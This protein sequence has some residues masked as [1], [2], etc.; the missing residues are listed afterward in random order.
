MIRYV[1]FIIQ[2]S[3]LTCVCFAQAAAAGRIPT[4]F[5]SIVPQKYFVQ[6][7]SKGRV[8][9][10]V[11]VQPGANPATYEPKPSQMAKL[12]SAAAYF[13]IGVPF[14]T[15]WLGKMS[16]INPRME[17]VR[18][19]RQIEKIAMAVHLHEEELEHG[20]HSEVDQRIL[21][22][23]IWL[24]PQLVKKQIET[25]LSGLTAIAPEYEEEFTPNSMIFLKKIDNLSLE[26]HS[27]L[28]GVKGKHFMVFHPS[29]GYFAREFGLI[30]VPIEIEG[31]APKPAQLRDLILYARDRNINIIFAQPQFSRK[32]ASLVAREIN[33]E[34]LFVDPL[35]EDWLTNLLVVAEKFNQAAK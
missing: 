2:F 16:G 12:S 25:I 30:Q 18:T 13:A 34:V 1:L 4:V 26:L 10:E 7:I 19:D 23:H 6:Q 33:G 28:K 32:N 11:M 3:V 22:P 15:A 24:S 20:D 5:V 8:Q 17:I 21:D 9:V 35:A 31:K 29:W 14:E 27:L